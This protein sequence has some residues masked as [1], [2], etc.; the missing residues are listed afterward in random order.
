MEDDS[1]VTPF[2][3]CSGVLDSLQITL[4]HF[5]DFLIGGLSGSR[6][7][8]DQPFDL[9]WLDEQARQSFRVLA[10]FN[11]LETRQIVQTDGEGRS[12]I[13]CLPRGAVVPRARIRSLRSITDW[14]KDSELENA[15]VPSG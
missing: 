4:E 6:R 7:C 9:P 12:R 10:A 2:K 15:N 5:H 11:G 14:I 8:G 1:G 3:R 13:A